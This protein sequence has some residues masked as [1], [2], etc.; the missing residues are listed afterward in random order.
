MKQLV[1]VANFKNYFTLAEVIEWVKI[2]K[3]PL[4][5]LAADQKL[6]LCPSFEALSSIA[7]LIKDCPIMLG[8]QD[9]SPFESGAHTGQVLA[10]S[11][12]QIGCTWAII[13]HSET[14]NWSDASYI[15]LKAAQLLKHNITPIICVGET[16]HDYAQ[17]QGAAIIE[18]QIKTILTGW[19]HTPHTQISIAYEPIWAINKVDPRAYQDYLVAQ[20]ALI[21]KLCADLL[22]DYQIKLFYGGGVNA[23][24]ATQVKQMPHIDGLLIGKASTDFQNLQKIVG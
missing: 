10:E 1:Y 24:N 6:V 20:L 14:H 15:R 13:G 4:T 3:V 16:E 18:N 22:P 5:Q 8:A 23:A 2:N 19:A 21:K 17:Q 7:S 11:L 9:C 12:A